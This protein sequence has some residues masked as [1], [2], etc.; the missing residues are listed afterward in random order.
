MEQIETE[1]T[2]QETMITVNILF[3]CFYIICIIVGI[4]YSIA[5]SEV[6]LDEKLVVIKTGN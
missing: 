4:I 2:N 6:N 5:T 3:R 1:I